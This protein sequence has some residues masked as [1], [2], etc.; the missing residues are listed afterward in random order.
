MGTFDATIDVGDPDGTRFEPV[1]AMVDTGATFTSLPASFLRGLGVTPMDRQGFTMANG[2]RFMLEIGETA[3]RID[4][5]TRTSIVVFAE[6][7]APALLGAYTL[8]A[9]SLAADPVNRRLIYVDS[10]LL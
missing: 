1:K 2:Q 3:F 6:D 10:L 4:G 9:F 7:D 8:E 5:R